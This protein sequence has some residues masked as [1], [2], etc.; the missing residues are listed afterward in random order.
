MARN[1]I[2]VFKVSRGVAIR[3]PADVVRTLSIRPGEYFDLL[4]SDPNT[5]VVRR[6]K[7]IRDGEFGEARDESLPIIN[8][9]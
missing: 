4:I 3:L 2:K 7:I 9:G 1:F 5:M 8:E 6:L